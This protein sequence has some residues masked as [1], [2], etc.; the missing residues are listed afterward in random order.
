MLPATIIMLIVGFALAS[1]S[2]NGWLGLIIKG[3]IFAVIYIPVF[4]FIGFNKKERRT[5]PII[6]KLK[7]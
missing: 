5:L 2:L 7:I 4:L 1:L 6:N 3:V